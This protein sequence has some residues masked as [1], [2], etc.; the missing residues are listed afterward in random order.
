VCLQTGGPISSSGGNCLQN[1]REIGQPPTKPA[2]TLT[3]QLTSSSLDEHL[4]FG[5]ST[6]EKPKPQP[7]GQSKQ[8]GL[9]LRDKEGI[10]I[11]TKY[12]DLA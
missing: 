11:R 12:V 9:F 8:S 5:Q 10:N 7:K 2:E 3:I 6:N 1:A 4:I